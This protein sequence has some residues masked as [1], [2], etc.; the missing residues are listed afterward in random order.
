MRALV[1]IVI[2]AACGKGDTDET[3]APDTDT[4][5]PGL[6]ERA[7]VFPDCSPDDG[8][9]ARFAIGEPDDEC[10]PSLDPDAHPLMIYTFTVPGGPRTFSIGDENGSDASARFC[11]GG[12]ST[13]TDAVGGELVIETWTTDTSSTGT[14]RIELRDG[15]NLR[16]AF[17]AQW[18]PDEV[19]CG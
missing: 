3:D 11:P 12:A 5:R 15:T 16:G 1:P 9:A 17:S 19:Q 13:C 7:E 8:P 18:C 10:N 4:D 6:S 14:Y 2:L